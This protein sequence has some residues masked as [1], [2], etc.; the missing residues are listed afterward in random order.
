M[1]RVNKTEKDIQK[2][3]KDL[4]DVSGT[5]YNVLTELSQMTKLPKSLTKALDQFDYSAV[6][7]LKN[8]VEELLEEIK[9]KKG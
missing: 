6:V 3:W 1:K 2:I 8:E 4:D 5:L 9:N 7:I